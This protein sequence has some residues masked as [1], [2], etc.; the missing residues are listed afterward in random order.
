M[1]KCICVQFVCVGI[2]FVCTSART[3]DD[4]DVEAEDDSTVADRRRKNDTI[5]LNMMEQNVEVDVS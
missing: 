5:D 3:I 4:S 2:N 1:C